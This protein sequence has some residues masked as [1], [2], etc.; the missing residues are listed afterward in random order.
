[1]DSL[2]VVT[3]IDECVISS[4]NKGNTIK[5]ANLLPGHILMRS[6]KWF[7]SNLC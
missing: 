2:Q 1:M 4:F 7:E 5:F 6:K 3:L